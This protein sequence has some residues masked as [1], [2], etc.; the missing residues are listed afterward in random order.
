MKPC[1]AV[2]GASENGL[3][4]KTFS[5]LSKNVSDGGLFRIYCGEMAQILVQTQV[6]LRWRQ[7]N[8]TQLKGL[9]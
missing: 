1:S 8:K 9:K 3:T 6:T 7:H 5:T 4:F 2:N